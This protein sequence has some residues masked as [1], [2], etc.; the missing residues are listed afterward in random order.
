MKN[1]YLKVL[2][3]LS[4]L[5]FKILF[6]FIFQNQIV[7]LSN[8]ICENLGVVP[9]GKQV[10]FDGIIKIIA[11]IKLSFVIVDILLDIIILVCIE[12]IFKSFTLK[13]FIYNYLIVSFIILILI[14]LIF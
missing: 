5:F 6:W 14:L 1:F 10:I 9:K 13:R 11:V 2:I 3:I 8:Y 7:E 4:V 12:H